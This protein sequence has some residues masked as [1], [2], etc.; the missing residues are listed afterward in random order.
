VV[1]TIV[2]AELTDHNPNV[3]WELGVRQ[4][5]KHST[6]TIAEEETVL[7]FDI[8]A[9]T[10]LFYNRDDEKKITEFKLRILEA[11][12]DCIENPNKSDSQVLDTLSGR[13]LLYEIMKLD[14]VKRRIEALILE[15]KLNLIHFINAQKIVSYLKDP[16]Y[17]IHTLRYCA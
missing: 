12:S 2:I 16:A 4:S 13:G 17:I 8:S 10:T 6:I 3:F 15:L 1:S 9:K 11:I 7:P 5:F 14:E